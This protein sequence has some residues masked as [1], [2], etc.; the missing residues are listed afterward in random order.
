MRDFSAAQYSA[1]CR[2]LKESGYRSL[3]LAEFFGRQASLG[4]T[5]KVVLLRHDVDRVPVT[6]LALARIEQGLGLRASYYFRVPASFSPAVIGEVAA[7][8][9]EIGLHYESLDKARGDIPAALRLFAEDLKRLRALAP[10]TTIAMHGN[11]STPHDNR[12][13]WRHA[14][15]EDFGLTGEAYLTPDF[16]KL[17][18]YSDTGRTW[19]EGRANLFDHLPEGAA[20]PEGKRSAASTGDLI[21][22][23]RQETRNLYLVTHPERW[24]SS[25]PGWALSTAKDLAANALKAGFRVLY[26][27]R[28]V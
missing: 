19:R 24:P 13:L 2:A 25:L 5:D 26:R 15:L 3:T 28:P 23:I 18:Y 1:L 11:P 4:L 21:A 6:A 14:R 7:L 12:H 8:G 22:V 17:L 20:E 16:G 27:S 10:V 9:H